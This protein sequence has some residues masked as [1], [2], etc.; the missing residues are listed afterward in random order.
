MRGNATT[1]R[2]NNPTTEHRQTSR[3]EP[4]SPSPHTR[5][6][7]KS[8]SNTPKYTGINRRPGFVRWACSG[9]HFITSVLSPYVRHSSRAI[10]EAANRGGVAACVEPGVFVSSRTPL[11]RL[12]SAP[13]VCGW[14][15]V[16]RCLHIFLGLRS[17]EEAWLRA[18]NP[19][20]LFLP[21]PHSRDWPRHLRCVNGD[22]F[23]AVFISSSI[24]D[25]CVGTCW[26]WRSFEWL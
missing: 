14:R 15:C 10:E 11:P 12:A 25:L 5:A 7:A 22:V 23:I 9:V 17:V 19:V 13:P 1:K 24:F 4:T 8:P 16:H 3:P 26:R 6:T 18:W 21:G 2:L 20:S